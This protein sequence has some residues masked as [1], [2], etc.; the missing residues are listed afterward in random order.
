M[1][2]PN[3]VTSGIFLNN[4]HALVIWAKQLRFHMLAVFEALRLLSQRSELH[5][6]LLQGGKVQGEP[7]RTAVT[8]R[9]LQKPLPLPPSTKQLLASNWKL[10]QK[11]ERE[12]K[13]KKKKKEIA[14][15]DR[16]GG[17]GRISLEVPA[18]N[19]F[20]LHSHKSQLA[21]ESVCSQTW[22]HYCNLHQ[23]KLSSHHTRFITQASCPMAGLTLHWTQK[24]I[25]EGPRP[26][27]PPGQFQTGSTTITV[28]RANL[29]QHVLLAPHFWLCLAILYS[30]ALMQNLCWH[31][32]S[33]QLPEVVGPEP[34]LCWTRA[35]S[36]DWNI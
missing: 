23:Q 31:E 10:F 14:I 12:E 27:S 24:P 35:Q 25:N 2:A 11:K 29:L 18:Y 15:W 30:S 32:A 34:L 4:K 16:L 19:S 26:I 17:G 28:L 1:S 8:Q 5:C 22:G 6:T 20:I 33:H 13:K 36:I 7:T 3:N 9:F 21:A